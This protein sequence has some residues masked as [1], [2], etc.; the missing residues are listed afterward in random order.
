MASLEPG[1]R[2]FIRKGAIAAGAVVVGGAGVWAVAGPSI[3]LPEP[4]YP[5]TS[6]PAPG[7]K[8]RTLI[9]YA[10]KAGSTA[11]IAAFIAQRLSERGL[12]VDVRRV[13][14]VTTLEGYDT[15]VVGSAIR[16]GR[17][18]GE[19]ERFV[20]THSAALARVQ[21]ASF[22]VCMTLQKDT[23]ENRDV[24][25]AYLKPL[26]DVFKPQRVGLF[27]GKMDRARLALIPRLIVK[28]MK[29]PEGD[30]R[31]WS[32]IR[33]WADTLSDQVGTA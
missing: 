25:K 17:W 16:A 33:A 26:R 3:D 1:R 11:E 6:G 20:R 18:L 28:A 27:A 15:V 23:P 8:G 21:T 31:D 4:S 9:A 14:R 22:T 19:A 7:R 13:K 5:G 29:A 32:A 30:F 10:S 12:A 2:R 24:V